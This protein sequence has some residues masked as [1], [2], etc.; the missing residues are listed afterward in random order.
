MWLVTRAA[1]ALMAADEGALQVLRDGVVLEIVPA[2]RLPLEG[3][4]AYAVRSFTSCQELASAAA[5]GG[6]ADVDAVLYD[7]ENWRFTPVEEQVDLVG[8][9]LRARE[10]ADA[11]GVRLIAAPAVS[12]AKVLPVAPGVQPGGIG[13]NGRGDRYDRYLR[14]GIATAAAIA[15]VVD[16]QAQGAER[17]PR[18]YAAFVREATLQVHAVNPSATILAGL[19]TN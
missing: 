13:D 7:S 14:A 1:L 17:D 5:S 3:I 12:L 19:S 9:M 11:A 10:A 2:G 15:D 4:D 18:R 6:L 8:S 16:I